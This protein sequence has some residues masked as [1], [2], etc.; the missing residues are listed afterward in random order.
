[1]KTNLPVSI[2][3]DSAAEAKLKAA[4]FE[5]LSG[6]FSAKEWSAIAKKLESKINRS[7]IRMI[8]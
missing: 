3:A 2:T 8:L 1:M 6:H 5:K 7:R 4:A